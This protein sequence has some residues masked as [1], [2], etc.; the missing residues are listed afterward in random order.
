MLG[1]NALSFLA[2]SDEKRDD[3]NATRLEIINY[4]LQLRKALELEGEK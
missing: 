3:L 2:Y 1:R 4:I